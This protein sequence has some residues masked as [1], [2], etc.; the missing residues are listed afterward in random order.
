LFELAEE[1]LDE[2]ARAIER[3]V[4][5]SRL[6]AVGLGRDDRR[7]TA[8]CERTDERI[9]VVALVGEQRVRLDAIEQRGGLRDVRGSPWR[10][11]Q[12]HGIAECV[13]DSVNLGRQSASARH[14]RS[15]FQAFGREPL[16]RVLLARVPPLASTPRSMPAPTSPASGCPCSRP[17]G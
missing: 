14:I 12:R 9:G 13:H 11:R 17:H 6:L 8:V 5:R 2:I 7:D 4:C 1:A 16:Y 10:Q 15:V 3:D